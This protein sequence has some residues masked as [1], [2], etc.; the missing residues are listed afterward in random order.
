MST[1]IRFS[2]PTGFAVGPVNAYLF[3]DPEPVL[4]DTGVKSE[5]SIATLRAGLAEH[6]LTF[7][8]LAKI[9]ISHPHTDHCAIA[10]VIA[11]ESQA[12]FHI[13]EPTKRWLTH[14][15]E[16]SVERTLFHQN[17]VFAYWQLE[18]EVR[19]PLTRDPHQHVDE[20]ATVHPDRVETFVD[21]DTMM[22]GGLPWQVLYTPGHA[23]T[24]TC[25][26]QPDTRQF[27]STDMLLPL[28]PTPIEELPLAGESKR[29][30]P[31]PQFI[32]SLQR[33]EALDC[34]IVYPGHGDPFTDHRDLINRQRSRIEM[35][36]AQCLSLLKEGINTLGQLVLKMYPTYSPQARFAGVW[37]TIGYLDLLAADGEIILSE[38]DQDGKT[39]VDILVNQ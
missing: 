28:T 17:E 25:Y 4:I 6:D 22:M 8:D 26:Y 32:E 12:T 34:D 13:Y 1:P 37:M 36:K 16:L 7:A 19:L 9:V 35:R 38:Y 15:P 2:L 18:D 14:Y 33:V 30:P 29:V 21:G 5:E 20:V 27:L 39:V 23:N 11:D 24:L 31:L 10:G 3:T